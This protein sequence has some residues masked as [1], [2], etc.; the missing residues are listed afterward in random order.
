MSMLGG[1][2]VLTKET[3]GETAGIQG[4]LRLNVIDASAKSRRK[5][6]AKKG[7]KTPGNRRNVVCQEET[8]FPT[9][10]WGAKT[11]RTEK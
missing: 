1:W 5:G 3:E 7:N 11:A 9:V 4:S 8:A 6:H 2:K 10:V